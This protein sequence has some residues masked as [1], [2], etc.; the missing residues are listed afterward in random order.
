MRAQTEQENKSCLES[1]LDSL[2]SSL[3]VMHLGYILRGISLLGICTFIFACRKKL[4][5]SPVSGS[6][7][8]CFISIHIFNIKSHSL[9][10][11][12]APHDWKPHE[13]GA[14]ASHASRECILSSIHSLAEL[15]SFGP[16]ECTII[17][18]EFLVEGIPQ[19]TGQL[20]CK[21]HLTPT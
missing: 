14:W 2:W 7:T 10:I 16:Y 15:A 18:R 1:R 6:H 19:R 5:P 4:A 20:V 3:H 17:I 13:G 8:T 12:F 21:N 11:F 9:L